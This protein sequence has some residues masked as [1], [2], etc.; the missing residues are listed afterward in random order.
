MHNNN[1]ML[2][3]DSKII[4]LWWYGRSSFTSHTDFEE[5]SG[6]SDLLFICLTDFNDVIYPHSFSKCTQIYQH[7]CDET[8]RSRV[9][10]LIN[11]FDVL[12]C[13]RL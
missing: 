3:V 6:K 9:V 2:A 13:C 10:F 1:V 11:N 7:H 12:V 5:R 8:K 4:I